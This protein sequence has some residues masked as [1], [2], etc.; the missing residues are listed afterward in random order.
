MIFRWEYEP[1]S[2]FEIDEKEPLLN[3]SEYAGTYRAEGYGDITL[4]LPCERDEEALHPGANFATV[5]AKYGITYKLQLQ[6]L[7]PRLWS[8]HLRLVSIGD[9][10]CMYHQ[11]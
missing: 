1:R 11:T 3:L 9:N 8:S 2:F 4:H 7:W 5:D 6:A 10:R